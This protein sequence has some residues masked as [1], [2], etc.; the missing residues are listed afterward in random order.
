MKLQIIN[1]LD[2]EY[3]YQVMR[4]VKKTSSCELVYDVKD[5]YSLND[6]DAVIVITDCPEAQD[7]WLGS[8]GLDKEKI[9]WFT[10]KPMTDRICWFMPKV[11]E[12][13]FDF[14]KFVQYLFCV[15]SRNPQ[16]NLMKSMEFQQM[17]V[18]K[19]TVLSECASK[20]LKKTKKKE[21]VKLYVFIK[22]KVKRLLEE[23]KK[24]LS[25]EQFWIKGIAQEVD[26]VICKKSWIKS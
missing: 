25:V 16:I 21:D 7:S 18:S 2:L 12:K 22:D 17:R 3:P 5:K 20:V 6:A 13:E 1:C 14:D 11:F 4:I 15:I 19:D 26:V 9:I 23:G 10:D 8:V 24:N